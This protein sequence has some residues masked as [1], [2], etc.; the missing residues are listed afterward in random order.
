MPTSMIEVVEHELQG[1]RAS[2]LGEAG[3]KI[4][5]AMAA[6]E[7]GTDLRGPDFLL[8]EAATA[9]WYFIILRESLRWFDHP[10]ALKAYGI[11]PRVMARVGVVKPR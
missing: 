10:E 2:A 9:V 4:E 8:D 6:L 7:A 5:A 1:E 11:P 3:R